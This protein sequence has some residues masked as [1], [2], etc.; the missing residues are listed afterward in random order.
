MLQYRSL[1]SLAG[2][3]F[4]SYYHKDCYLSSCG[5]A[6]KTTVSR[7]PP[8]NAMCE[9]ST[10][11]RTNPHRAATRRDASLSGPQVSS[12]RA[13]P[14]SENAHRASSRARPATRRTAGPRDHRSPSAWP[15][16]RSRAM[17]AATRPHRLGPGP[18][19]RA[20]PLRDP[21]AH[22]TPPARI[23]KG[24]RPVEILALV[25]PS[26]GLLNTRAFHG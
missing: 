20:L 4:G 16:R 9:R 25:R 23:W 18:G 22:L 13:R 21:T 8:L 3:R 6:L 19:T 14:S 12:R 10:P 5:S 26:P 1:Q 7:R 15:A 24:R 2:A 11:S 17:G